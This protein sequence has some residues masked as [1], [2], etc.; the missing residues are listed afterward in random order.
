MTYDKVMP[1]QNLEDIMVRLTAC[2]AVLRTIHADMS[3]ESGDLC[4][5][6]Y[7][8]CDLLNSICRDF[9]ADIAAAEDYEVRND[10]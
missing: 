1:G 5:A 10:G 9:Q 8:A 3:P 6:I 2:G 7:G 4:D